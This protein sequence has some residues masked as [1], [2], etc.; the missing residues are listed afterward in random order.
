VRLDDGDGE[1]SI[2][3]GIKADYE[4][5]QLVGRYVVIVANL[6]PKKMRFGTSEGMILAAGDAAAFLVSPDDGAEAGMR[7][8]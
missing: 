7:V 1:R 5:D 6:A 3:A 4:P 2:L 8:R